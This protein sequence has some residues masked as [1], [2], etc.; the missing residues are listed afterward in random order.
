MPRVAWKSFTEARALVRGLKL[1]GRR[2][3]TAWSKSGHRPSDIPGNPSNTYRD[4]GW[5]SWPDW[6]GYG[7]GRVLAKDM[8]PFT[9]GRAYARKLKLG[10][11]KEWKEWSKSGQRPSNIPGNPHKVYRD[12]GWI[13]WPDWLGNGGTSHNSMLPFAAGRAYVRKL[14]LRN[15]KEWKEWSKSG[16]RPSNIPGN[17]QRT[18]RDDGWISMPDWLGYGSSGGAAASRSSS[19]SSSAATTPKKKTKKKRKRHPTKAPVLLKVQQRTKTD[20]KDFIADIHK[21]H[22][23]ASGNCTHLSFAVA[24]FCRGSDVSA[25]DIE[26]TPTEV[27]CPDDVETQAEWAVGSPSDSDEEPAGDE[28]KRVKKEV[29]VDHELNQGSIPDA[30]GMVG[31][32]II[33][34]VDD[35]GSTHEVLDVNNSAVHVQLPYVDERK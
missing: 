7:E 2:G 20:L 12:D 18:Y 35:D 24:A 31:P 10:S 29:I 33:V 19:S 3:W 17:P 9:V 34:T 25:A 8:L 26:T 5:I 11:K 14:K 6:L 28:V 27:W 16:Q 4:A 21:Q 13:S 1:K 22:K 15:N 32:R 30:M 23:V